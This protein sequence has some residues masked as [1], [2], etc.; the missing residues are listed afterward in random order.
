[1]R[2]AWGLAPS[3]LPGVNEKGWIVRSDDGRP[4]YKQYP[5]AGVPY[6]DI[7]AYQSGTEGSLEGTEDGIDAD[8]KWLGSEDERLGYPTQQP[9]GLL[10]RII[11]PQQT[12]A[13]SCSTPFADAARR[14]TPPKNWDAGDRH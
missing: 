13:R 6:Q 12:M 2:P 9:V 7:W 14:I 1:M 5:G 3:L 11:E 8:V 4:T 10:E